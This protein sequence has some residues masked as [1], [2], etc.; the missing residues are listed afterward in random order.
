MKLVYLLIII[1]MEKVRFSQLQK[2]KDTI[3]LSDKIEYLKKKNVFINTYYLFIIWL[4]I[5]WIIWAIRYI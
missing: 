1:T 4:F 3:K 2:I 5:V